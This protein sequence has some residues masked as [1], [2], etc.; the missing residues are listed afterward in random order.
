MLPLVKKFLQRCFFLAQ[1]WL[2]SFVVF[3]QNEGPSVQL[4]GGSKITSTSAQDMLVNIAKS[5][6]NLMQLVTAFAYVMG[7]YLI[8]AGIL[9][10]KHFG[11]SRTMMSQEHSLKGPLILLTIGALL[12]YLPTA[13][14]V[15][16]STFW[17]EPNPYGYL[18][19]KD[20]WSQFLNVCYLIVQFI[21]TIAFIRGLLTLSHL[22]GHGG[23]QPGTFAKGL[24]YVIG[25]ILCINIYQ[26]VQVIM[27]TLGLG[28]Y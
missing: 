17:T 13:V 14:Q 26:F 19:E 27:V 15:G 28:S 8:F 2:L 24:T 9:R 23:N 20:Q 25:G 18:Q 16:L 4:P 10:L 7:M 21:G 11:E 6:P 1:L 12:L 22:G 5:I 3:A